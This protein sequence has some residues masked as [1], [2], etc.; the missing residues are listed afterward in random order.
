MS[1]FNWMADGAS[2]QQ[3]MQQGHAMR[4]PLCTG[5]RFC[6]RLEILREGKRED[7]L[8]R[9]V[10]ACIAAGGRVCDIDAIVGWSIFHCAWRVL[11]TVE[12]YE[13]HERRSERECADWGE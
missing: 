2:T 4:T 1:E 12:L 6:D 3:Y 8:F 5:W 10:V 11:E 7:D 9:H 13:A